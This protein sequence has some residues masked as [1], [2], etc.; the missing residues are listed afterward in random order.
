[1]LD[2][3]SLQGIHLDPS[4]YLMDKEK[5]DDNSRTGKTILDSKNSSISVERKTEHQSKNGLAENRI[6]PTKENENFVK[7]KDCT[8]EEGRISEGVSYAESHE[9]VTHDSAH[10]QEKKI[11]KM[12]VSE[13]EININLLLVCGQYVFT[14][15]NQRV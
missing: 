6:S 9:T 4:I 15:N 11:P 13:K 8:L 14:C 12:K 7:S 1:M 3:I 10:S 5:R 2:C